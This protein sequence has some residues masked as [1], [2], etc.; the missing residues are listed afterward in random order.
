MSMDK[1]EFEAKMLRWAVKPPDDSKE[2]VTERQEESEVVKYDPWAFLEDSFLLYKWCFE[3]FERPKDVVKAL[4]TGDNLAEAAATIFGYCYADLRC[5]SPEKQIDSER[6][7]IEDYYPKDIYEGALSEESW[8]LQQRWHNS[9]IEMYFELIDI[10]DRFSM[11][12]MKYPHGPKGQALQ[13]YVKVMLCAARTILLG[14]GSKEYNLDLYKDLSNAYQI[15][16]SGKVGEAEN[17]AVEKF[18][19]DGKHVFDGVLDLLACMAC[20]VVC[21]SYAHM[22]SQLKKPEYE[23]DYESAFGAYVK[24]MTFVNKMGLSIED[25]KLPPFLYEGIDDKQLRKILDTW[26]Q[27]KNTP[28]RVKNWRETHDTFKKLEKIINEVGW[29]YETAIDSPFFDFLPRQEEFCEVQERLREKHK[30]RL[31]KLLEGAWDGLDTNTQRAL[32]QMEICLHESPEQGGREEAA[33]NELRHAFIWELKTL[34]FNRAAP[35]LISTLN[36]KKKRKELGIGSKASVTSLDL[37]HMATFLKEAGERNCLRVLSFKEFVESLIKSDRDRG[38]LYNELP[39]YLRELAEQR[40]EKEHPGAKREKGS[41]LTRKM[42]EQ[43]DI[44]D[45]RS[46]ALGIGRPSYLRR[47]V[48]IKKAIKLKGE[49]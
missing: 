8:K 11:D 43:K 49:A 38:F 7:N 22:G 20:A 24:A 44:W 16:N 9:N 28:D 2:E 39:D 6:E 45:L 21:Y 35:I 41:S 14:N 13:L 1:A 32:V 15:V 37:Q 17:F 34:L 48:E 36:D 30:K 12:D 40:A 33:P 47:L 18:K 3:K 19:C 5:T 4:S 25:V 27:V 10:R 26:E 23:R 31:R 29:Y 42:V 46:E